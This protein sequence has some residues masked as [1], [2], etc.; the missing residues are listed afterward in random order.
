LKPS[1]FKVAVCIG[2]ATDYTIVFGEDRV[3]ASGQWLH[4][5]A[6]FPGIV[7]QDIRS[8]P[9]RTGQEGQRYGNG[10]H[11]NGCETLRRAR[12]DLWR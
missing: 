6:I 8:G 11:E 12:T 7:D 3:V 2:I 9:G 10:T 1:G 5:V 4:V